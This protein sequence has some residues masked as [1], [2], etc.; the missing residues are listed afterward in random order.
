MNYIEMTVYVMLVR[1]EV[2]FYNNHYLALINTARCLV[3]GIDD[4]LFR[5]LCIL[6]FAGEERIMRGWPSLPGLRVL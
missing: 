6:D 4:M 1:D 3:R 5:A 2:C